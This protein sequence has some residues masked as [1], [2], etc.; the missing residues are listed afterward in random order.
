MNYL[1][2]KGKSDE[3]YKPIVFFIS[4]SSAPTFWLPLRRS[5]VSTFSQQI[6]LLLRLKPKAKKEKE[7]KEGEK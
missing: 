7:E 2:C 3:T 1:L 5:T 6:L 4:T